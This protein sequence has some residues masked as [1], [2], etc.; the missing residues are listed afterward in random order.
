MIFVSLHSYTVGVTC[1]AG[2]ANPS[3][4]PDFSPGVEWVHVAQFA[5][6]CVV[7]CRLLFGLSFCLFFFV[8]TLFCLSFHLRLLIIPLCYLQ[9]LLAFTKICFDFVLNLFPPSCTN[10]TFCYTNKQ[11]FS[12]HWRI[13]FLG[14]VMVVIV[15]QLDLWLPMQSVPITTKLWVRT[16]LRR[17]VLDTTLCDNVCQ[18]LATC[19]WLSP[20]TP[21]S[22]TNKTDRHNITEILL[23]VTLNT[24]T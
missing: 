3:G 18:W 16:P 7:I 5:V 17:G 14:D 8:W 2:T 6:F 20:D 12:L 21:V 13:P 1:R 9:N 10:H 15:W 22:S 11:P 4:A 24:I 19:R 23:N